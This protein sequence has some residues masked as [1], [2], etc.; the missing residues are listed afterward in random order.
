MYNAPETRK[1][2]GNLFPIIG[3]GLLL[4]AIAAAISTQSFINTASR[5][6][7]KVV[8]LYAG[9]AHPEIR[10]IPAGETAIEFSGHGFINYAVGDKVSVLYR[11][12]SQRPAGYETQIDTPGALWSSTVMFTYLGTGFVIGGLYTKHHCKPDA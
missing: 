11:K 7:G 10:F 3:V 5:T 4:G 2:V 8:K 6:E 9:G 12:D 1:L